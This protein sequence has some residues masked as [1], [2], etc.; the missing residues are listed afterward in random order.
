VRA[1]LTALLCVTV[2]T[3]TFALGSFPTL[4]PDL[5]R[6]AQL[7]TLELG[8]LISAFAFARMLI[9]I[10]VGLFVARRLR[11]AVLGAPFVLVAG[12]LMIG[13]GGPFAVLLAGRILMGFAHALGMVAWL[14]L[15]LRQ[16]GGS[17][18]AALNAFELSAMLGMLGGVATVGAL[19]KTV[20]WNHAYLVASAPLLVGLVTA[21]LIAASL[22]VAAPLAEAAPAAP[23]GRRRGVPSLPALAFATGISIAVMYATIEQFLLPL[24]ASREFGLD[25]VAVARLLM[26]AQGSDIVALL[27]VGLLAD[28]A[29]VTR[30]LATILCVLAAA[31]ALVSFGG[32]GA[33][34]AGAALF[35][36][37]MAGWMLPLALLRRQTPAA[38]IAWRTALYRV[39]VDGGLFLGPFVCGL[40]GDAAW[41][42]ATAVAVVL[43]VLAIILFTRTTASR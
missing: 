31:A 6:V 37:G 33:M 1:R 40:L 11:W 18:G 42:L 25:R 15:I 20:A 34:A 21:P 39:G 41:T 12:V 3:S 38:G 9:D 22:P 17:L 35:G 19:P 26:I 32:P 16:P 4:L 23:P 13:T 27:P 28:R 8:V 7:S 24:R 43:V 30:V 14:T 36:L 5:D 29:G 10:P 2:G